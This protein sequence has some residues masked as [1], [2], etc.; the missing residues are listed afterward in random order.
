MQ[1]EN[2]E[3]ETFDAGAFIR[4]Y[5]YMPDERHGYVIIHGGDVVSSIEC[6]TADLKSDHVKVIGV[7][8]VPHTVVCCRPRFAAELQK[9][10]CMQKIHM[11]ISQY[12]S[13]SDIKRFFY[14]LWLAHHNHEA[15]RE[16]RHEFSRHRFLKKRGLLPDQTDG[17][18]VRLTAGVSS[19]EAARFS[20]GL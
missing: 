12:L 17:E 5:V 13:D 18:I 4:N 3:H 14:D 20:R 2:M 11:M 1:Q 9:G 16:N 6:K 8:G 19:R 7:D 10:G 15:A